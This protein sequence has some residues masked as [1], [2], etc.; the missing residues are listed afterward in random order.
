MKKPIVKTDEL[1][2]QYQS[3]F[4]DVS[5]IIDA[6]RRSAARS[7]NAVMTAA[8]WM[9]GQH[10]VEFEQSGEERAEYGTALI[11]KAGGGFD[12]AVWSGFRSCQSESDEKIL[13]AMAVR[14]N[15]SDTCLK[16]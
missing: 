5:I 4:G 14:T 11:K 10:I 9:I 6:A 12:T 7:V 1:D 8:Y 13:S 2:A 16:N 15:F 3:I